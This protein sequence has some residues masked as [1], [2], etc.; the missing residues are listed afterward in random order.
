M[1]NQITLFLTKLFYKNFQICTTLHIPM[2]LNQ[3][4]KYGNSK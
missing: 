3:D 4:L 1:L 2:C